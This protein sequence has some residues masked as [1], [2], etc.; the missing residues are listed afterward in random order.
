MKKPRITVTERNSQTDLEVILSDPRY[1]AAI[2]NPFGQ[3]S[4][5]IALK[6]ASRECH[7]FYARIQTDHIWRKKRLGWDQVRPD[8]VADLEQIGGYNVSTEGYITRG[9]RGEEILMSMP[10]AVVHARAAAKIEWNNRH[11]GNPAAMKSEVVEA[12]SQ[13]LGDQAAEFLNRT[14]L[15]GGVTDVYERIARVEPE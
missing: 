12:A 11:M 1:K 4:S 14:G 10:K 5:P 2:D 7:W 15:V 13:R 3:P 6:D 8:D 9:E